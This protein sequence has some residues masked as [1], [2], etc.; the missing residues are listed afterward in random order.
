VS[1]DSI[2][3]RTDLVPVLKALDRSG[4]DPHNGNVVGQITPSIVFIDEIHNLSLS[5]QEVLGIMM[6]EWYVTVSEGIQVEEEITKDPKYKGVKLAERWCPR[7]TLIG[8]TTNDGKLSKP[9]RDRF[10]LR[11]NF[12]TYSVQESV[13]IVKVHAER[14]GIGIDDDAAMEIAKRGR[15][16]P[17]ILVKYLEA[18]RDFAFISNLDRINFNAARLAFFTMGVDNAGLT[19][20]DIK[21]LKLL[22]EAEKPIGIDNLSVHLNES[23]KV[24]T[25]AIEPFLIQSGLLLRSAKGRI[26]TPKGRKYLIAEGHISYVAPLYYDKP[27]EIEYYES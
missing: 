5:G 21:I 9:F 23:P 18:C 8:A 19:N 3:G 22:N 13:E 27:L 6:E 26:L 10:K 16:V 4:H 14:L 12:S 11:F 1:S 17:R 15:G 25:D 7:F 24:I 2:K 20:T